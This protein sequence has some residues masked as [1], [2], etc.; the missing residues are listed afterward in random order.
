MIQDI[1][2]TGFDFPTG[3]FLPAAASN[4]FHL[5]YIFSGSGFL[6]ADSSSYTCV[7]NSLLLFPSLS[8]AIPIPGKHS[9]LSVLHLTFTCSSLPLRLELS[10]L[11]PV[12]PVSASTRSLLTELLHECVSKLPFHEDLCALYLEQLLL[13]V[14]IQSTRKKA[15]SPIASQLSHTDSDSLSGIC[16]YIEKHLDQELSVGLLGQ[17]SY[18]NPRQL[19]H[20]FQ[21]HYQKT[22]TEY[23]N[24]CRLN[25][26]CELLCFTALPIT[27]IAESLGFRSIHYFSRF[28]KKR[29][30]ISPS[31]YRSQSIIPL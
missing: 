17:L 31:Q 9:D 25:R 20:L 3:P 13:P 14:I 30:G 28:F 23:I 4:Q 21:K 18:L 11:P 6:I 19:N 8:V 16:N 22:V 2:L 27:E 12:L 1:Q 10:K 29:E 7:K 24:D 26:A 5:F 15:V